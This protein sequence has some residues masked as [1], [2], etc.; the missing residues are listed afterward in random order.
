MV[1]TGQEIVAE[2]TVLAPS[3]SLNLSCS[4]EFFCC[5]LKEQALVCSFAGVTP[6]LMNVSDCRPF[7]TVCWTLSLLPPNE[8]WLDEN[9]RT[10]ELTGKSPSFA[11]WHCYTRA[12]S[13]VTASNV[14]QIQSLKTWFRLHRID[15]YCVC[16]STSEVQRKSNQ[17]PLQLL[18]HFL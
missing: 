7:A 15:L 18:L 14:V 9:T 17:C 2:A 16:T 1:Q 5:N 4:Q 10:H 12:G 3:L 6:Q 13:V 11:T 8:N